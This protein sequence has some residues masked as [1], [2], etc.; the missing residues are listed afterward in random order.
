M[1][2]GKGKG[3]HRNFM[4]PDTKTEILRL[5]KEGK[6]HKE[7]SDLVG[8]GL[9]QVTNYVKENQKGQV[10]VF[11]EEEDE[12]LIDL[13]LR[14]VVKESQISKIIPTKAP[15]MIRNRIR[16]FKKT[17]RLEEKLTCIDVPQPIYLEPTTPFVATLVDITD[18]CPPFQSDI[19]VDTDY[20][21]DFL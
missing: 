16:L 17:G 7:I 3:A 6:T 14:G 5:A 19:H 10:N 2:S 15:W 20:N 21:C 12:K 4:S 8:C 1:E 13:Y 9:R 18:I 11:T